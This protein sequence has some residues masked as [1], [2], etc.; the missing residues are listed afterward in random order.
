MDYT[1]NKFFLIGIKGTGMAN[2]AVLLSYMNAQVC[3]C[4]KKVEFDTDAVLKENNICVL[5]GFDSTL[6]ENQSFD[7]IIY[8]D[9]YNKD[10]CPV[11][12]Y[13]QTQGY[14]C[15]SYP[16]FLGILSS[17]CNCYAVSGTHG[18]TTTTAATTFALSQGG[19]KNY[20]FFSIFGSSLQKGPSLVFQGQEDMLVEASEYRNHFL[21]LNLKGALITSIELDHPDFFKT[22]EEV[23]ESFCSFVNRIQKGGFLIL[24]VD[25]ESV[26]KL[27][28]WVKKNRSDLILLEYGFN[29]KGPFRLHWHINKKEYSIELLSYRGYAFNCHK[30]I[31]SDYFGAS[32]LASCMLLNKPNPKLYFDGQELIS[33]EILGT[34]VG[35]MLQSLTEFCGVK[36]RGEIIFE[37]DGVIYMD[38]YA[39]HPTEIKAFIDNLRF[40]YPAQKIC[41]AFTPHTYSRTKVLL[42]DFVK[43]L[44]LGD[45]LVLQKTY[46]SAREDSGEDDITQELFERLSTA[47]LRS[48]LVRLSSVVYIQNDEDAAVYL[49][50]ALEPGAICV[51]LG[52]GNNKYL[53]KMVKEQRSKL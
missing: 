15:Y 14:S 40:K 36:G 28:Q 21:F 46:V 4:D 24:C 47:S 23:F 5:E 30:T 32:L 6:V 50:Q 18:K 37:E 9:A 35:S 43:A 31:A 26:K 13:C 29:A 11:L 51:S 19:R 22:E 2:L 38:D 25:T 16:E 48:I 10:N 52:A 12:A 3:G 1:K 45:V 7:F 27:G 20:P 17:N 39:H 34:L 33:D 41:M 44:S 53:L 8:S 42:N 49:A